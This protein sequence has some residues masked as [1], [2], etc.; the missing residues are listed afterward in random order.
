MPCGGVTGTLSVSNHGASGG[1]HAVSQEHTGAGRRTSDRRRGAGGPRER[2]A[3]PGHGAGTA[4]PR[5]DRRRGGRHRRS[6]LRQS[7]RRADPDRPE[8]R[9]AAGP[10]RKLDDLRRQADLYVRPA[11][12]GDVSRRCRVRFQRREILAGTRHGGRVDQRA[13]RPVRTDRGRCRAG[14]GNRGDHAETA[15]R[16]FPVESRLGR[17]GDRRPGIGRR[18]QDQPGRHRPL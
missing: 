1:K 10:C 3:D 4:A 6:G 17:R 14:P 2:H 12:R 11:H 18:Q 15:G 9:G 7:V 13:E 16:E 8:R 5:S